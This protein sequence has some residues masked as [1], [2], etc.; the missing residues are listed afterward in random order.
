[1]VHMLWYGTHLP[2]V[3]GAGV[4]REWRRVTVHVERLGKEK[5]V[6]V[7]VCVSVCPSHLLGSPFEGLGRV[8]YVIAGSFNLSKITAKGRDSVGEIN[9]LDR[10]NVSVWCR[11]DLVFS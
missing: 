6:C 11:G 10:T 2:G 8:E 1:M 7:Y 3:A 9:T 4:G 5:G